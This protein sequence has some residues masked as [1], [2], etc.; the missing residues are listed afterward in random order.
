MPM[1]I[2]QLADKIMIGLKQPTDKD[3]KKIA[4][5]NHAKALATA[6]INSLKGVTFTHALVTAT[7]GPADSPPITDGQALG[8]ILVGLTPSLYLNEMIKAFPD[9]NP[10]ILSQE[11]SASTSYLQASLL[12]NF[13]AG[14]I[15]G[16]CTATTNS[17][18]ILAAGQGVNGKVSGINGQS[19]GSTV[20][21]AMGA[22]SSP[23]IIDVYTEIANYIMENAVGSYQVGQ[24]TGVFPAGGGA[25]IGGIGAGGLLQ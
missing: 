13:E 20:L 25:L 9:S 22:S 14:S 5:T 18:G 3:G 2:A 19:W 7:G 21:S 4:A 8:G 11:A 6:I 1:D 23:Y 15:T 10:A 16:Q 12:I 24:V 17:P